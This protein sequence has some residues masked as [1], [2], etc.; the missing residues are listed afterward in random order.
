MA[1]VDMELYVDP[2]LDGTSVVAGSGECVGAVMLLEAVACGRYGVRYVGSGVVVRCGVVPALHDLESGVW[3]CGYGEIRDF[4]ARTYDLTLDHHHT[5][6]TDLVHARRHAYEALIA[7]RAADLTALWLYA[8]DTNYAGYTRPAVSKSLGMPFAYS[9]PA[10]RRRRALVRAK[11]LGFL[12]GAGHGMGPGEVGWE[13]PAGEGEVGRSEASWSRPSFGVWSRGTGPES[14][15]ATQRAGEGSGSA[16]PAA[17]TPGSTT[18]AGTLLQQALAHKLEAIADTVYGA[19]E[20]RLQRSRFLCFDDD[21]EDQ[22]AS[23]SSAAGGGSASPQKAV[24]AP[25]GLHYSPQKGGGTNSA[26]RHDRK[27]GH[28]LSSVDVLAAAHLLIH[29]SAAAAPRGL[30]RSRL[31]DEYPRVARYAEDVR[32]TIFDDAVDGSQI[33]VLSRGLL[34]AVLPRVSLPNASPAERASAL[35]KVALKSVRDFAVSW[36]PLG[37]FLPPRRNEAA[38]YEADDEEDEET[39]Q[40]NGAGASVRKTPEERHAARFAAWKSKAI[41]VATGLA[42]LIWFVV[43]NGLVQVSFDDD[44]E[45]E[46]EDDEEEEAVESDNNGGWR[47]VEQYEE[48]PDDEDMDDEDDD[49]LDDVD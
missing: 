4:L 30:V 20:S 27:T 28:R 37:P 10:A 16:T 23:P 46:D 42:G 22:V 12:E 7:T 21:D 29:L 33:T 24:H 44:E 19:L 15:S 45:S 39:T 8:E 34:D 17:R 31:R 32:A 48:Y 9:V 41:F 13:C 26:S 18:V 6:L 25:S 47:V 49:D 14:Q 36:N 3:V 35:G 38:E 1:V 43:S 2:P 11:E 40:A 5:S